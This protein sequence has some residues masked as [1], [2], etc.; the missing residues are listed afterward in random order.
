MPITPRG[1]RPSCSV[2]T[3]SSAAVSGSMR[4]AGVF[5][6]CARRQRGADELW[7]SSTFFLVIG[8]SAAESGSGVGSGLVGG[9]HRS[10]ETRVPGFGRLVTGR[11]LAGAQLRTAT[12]RLAVRIHHGE[13]DLAGHH[14]TEPGPGLQ[15]DEGG[16]VPV[17]QLGLQVGDL[18]LAVGD[19]GLGGG[20]L[21]RLGE[22]D[23]Q[24]VR[25]RD[26]QHQDHDRERHRAG[27]Q[28][29]A[30][31]RPAHPGGFAAFD[32]VVRAVRAVPVGGGEEVAVVDEVA[33][34]VDGVGG[35]A[36][37]WRGAGIR[38]RGAGVLA[39]SAATTGARPTAAGTSSRS[40]GR[41]WARRHQAWY[42][43]NAEAPA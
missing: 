17:V 38:T 18:R 36:L 11:L 28:A 12:E 37:R 35:G 9:L 14:P 30:T 19:L 32:S 39:G 22:V 31:S 15:L 34:L 6:G 20:H 33:A 21:V 8:F 3:S 1:R 27:G 16:V 2:T 42:L 26:G 13:A 5:A 43:G 24:A 10:P 25:V 41:P 23:P 29:G 40:R 7:A 4:M